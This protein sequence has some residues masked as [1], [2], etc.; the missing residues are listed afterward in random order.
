LSETEGGKD[1]RAH[2]YVTGIVQGVAFRYYAQQ[3]AEELDVSGWVKNLLDGRVEAVF[4][5]DPD[6]VREIVAWCES[7]PSSA[8]VEDVTVKD[9]TPEGLTSFEVR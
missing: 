6:R 4:E 1:H 7:G 9:E 5:G 2:V 8:D 3:K